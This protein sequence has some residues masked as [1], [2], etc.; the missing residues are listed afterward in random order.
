MTLYCSSR[1]AT[2]ASALAFGG[3]LHGQSTGG[4]VVGK[5]TDTSGAMIHESTITLRNAQ[6]QEL[7]ETQPYVGG[8]YKFPDVPVG[9]YDV[10]VRAA[11]FKTAVL[12]RLTVALDQT[13]RADASLAYLGKA[14]SAAAG[15][16]DEQDAKAQRQAMF[17]ELPVVEAATLN[18]QTLSDVPA[19][20]SVVSAADIKRFGYRTLGEALSY[21]RGFYMTND[22]IYSYAG[23]RGLSIPGDYNTRFNVMINGHQMAENIYN[24]NGFFG[25]DFGLDMDLVQRIEV[26]R[27]PSSAIYGSNGVLTTIN[28]VTKAPA[29]YDRWRLSSETA[30]YREGKLFLSGARHLGKGVNLLFSGS[31][32]HGGSRSLFVPGYGSATGT[33]LQRGYH[34]FAAVTAGSW[35]FTS[36]FNKREKQPP[37]GWGE[38]LFDTRGNRVV[39]GRNFVDASYSKTLDDGSTVRFQTYYD[40]YRYVDRFYFD[41]EGEAQDARTYQHGDWIGTRASYSVP[42][43]KIGVLTVGVDGRFEIR[44]LHS[45]VNAT[46]VWVETARVSRPDRT[47]G[48]FAQ[49]EVDLSSRTKAY[50]G[51]RYDQS[52]N[53]GNFVSPQLALVHKQSGLTTFKMVYGRPFRNPSSFEQYFED[54]TQYLASN[55]LRQ[56]RAQAFEGSVE[57]KINSVFSAIVNGYHYRINDLIKAQFLEEQ[58]LQQYQ[59]SGA[60]KSTGVEFEVVARAGRI[61][62]DASMAVQKAREA[63]SPLELS[64]SPRNVG[65]ARFAI[66]VHKDVLHFSSGFQYLSQRTTRDGDF[67]R[68]V[69]LGDMTMHTNKLTR[70][71][72]LI[73]GLR[74]IGNY[75]FDDPVDLVSSRMRQTGRTV[76]LKLVYRVGE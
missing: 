46:P 51:L 65:K 20:V 2:I 63:G 24:S 22:R 45:Y 64:N 4:S 40:N 56:E 3:L 16:P 75:Q 66:P 41:N 25:Q 1:F 31:A 47:G 6:T 28:I 59:N 58:G 29:D 37:I 10:S 57:R 39:D 42:V 7:Q 32:F 14:K 21:V 30:S 54:G 35:R 44:A 70:N 23:V 33:D 62:A 53:F 67:T 13:V 17:E 34:S 60:Y 76:F 12:P 15:G 9:T 69:F 11:N 26:I 50:L 72:D 27:G 52:Q 36:Y 8:L 71:F 49:Q 38:S 68:A 55:G 48:A 61:L 43:K 73:G 74:N 5:I 19:N 18:A